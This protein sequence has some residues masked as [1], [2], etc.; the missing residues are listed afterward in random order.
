LLD[1]RIEVLTGGFSIDV[2]LVV[3]GAEQRMV[4]WSF[5]SAGVAGRL[6][7]VTKTSKADLLA[8]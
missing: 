3:D 4:S 1:G 6:L 8:L 7:G 2:R 5:F